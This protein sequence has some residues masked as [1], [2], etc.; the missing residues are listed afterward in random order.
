MAHRP[1][2]FVLLLATLATS[3]PPTWAQTQDQLAQNHKEAHA[4]R[5]NGD[6]IRLDGFL[7]KVAW[8]QAEP[9]SDF[10]QKE[11]VEGAQPSQRTEVRFVYDSDALYVGFRVWICE[12]APLQ[13]PLG[14]RV[15]PTRSAAYSRSSDQAHQP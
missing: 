1:R 10:V 7:D 6:A 4:Y 14:R 8:E 12:V 15:R 13:A 3:A 5:I 11:P 9:L 2:L